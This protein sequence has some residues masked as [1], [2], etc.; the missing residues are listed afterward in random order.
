MLSIPLRTRFR[1]LDQR[2]VMLYEG[3]AGPGEW[4]A[5]VEYDDEEAAWWLA[6]GIEQAFSADSPGGYGAEVPTNAI[7]P[8]MDPGDI[9]SWLRP[10]AGVTAVKVKVA[11][12]VDSLE[13]DL[14]RVREV[15]RVMGSDV[16]L[17]LD[18]NG[19]WSLAEADVALRAYSSFT[20][21]YV[22]QP[23]A[24]LNEMRALY[25][26]ARKLGIRLAADEL[27]RKTHSVDA[28]VGGG[29]CDV[30]IVK[31][32]PLGGRARTHALA[33][34]ALDAGLEV[35]VSS[36]VETSVGL[37]SAA[38]IAAE[39]NAKTGHHTVHGLGTVPLLASDVV[40]A[41]LIPQHG[42]V[43]PQKPALDYDAIERLRASSERTRWWHSRLERTLP[44][45]VEILG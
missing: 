25:P 28:V 35:V 15:E 33:S 17:R 9:E 4:A 24:T 41:P 13:R 30:V 6:A 38:L 8:A 1:G 3:P 36:G 21:D 12:T 37:T 16:A 14:E 23:V 44:R 42:I 34:R 40:T 27:V 19:R 7:V 45:A 10:F 39:L 5:F 29:V 32:S 11:D 43:T 26:L 2:E 18:V 31:P 22:E 20:L